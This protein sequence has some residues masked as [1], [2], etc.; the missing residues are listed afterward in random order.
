MFIVYW[1]SNTSKMKYLLTIRYHTWERSGNLGASFPHFVA[2][3]SFLEPFWSRFLENAPKSVSQIWVLEP[4]SQ[5]PQATFSGMLGTLFEL[6]KWKNRLQGIKQYWTLCES[7]YFT[8]RT[9]HLKC[10]IFEF[11]HFQIIIR[12]QNYILNIEKLKK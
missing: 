11:F 9:G 1:Y 4:G 5:P 2:D 6:L 8:K 12:I 7:V 10:I 3:F